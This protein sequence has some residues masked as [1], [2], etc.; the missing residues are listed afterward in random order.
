[1]VL[2]G[3]LGDT[4]FE[5]KLRNDNRIFDGNVRHDL[6]LLR[7]SGVEADTVSNLEVFGTDRAGEHRGVMRNESFE[8]LSNACGFLG[9]GDIYNFSVL[10]IS[11]D[12]AAHSGDYCCDDVYS[13]T[14]FLGEFGDIV[15]STEEVTGE[16]SHLCGDGNFLTALES[17]GL[18]Y[19]EGVVAVPADLEKAFTEVAVDGPGAFDSGGD[20]GYYSGLAAPDC[21]T[22][23]GA[24]GEPTVVDLA[25]LGDNLTL[26]VFAFGENCGEVF[27]DEDTTGTD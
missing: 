1:V 23:T 16:F 24:Y 2:E 11:N 10:W 13:L 6:G 25:E 14:L 27:E 18:G 26:V 22:L 21:R 5:G 12:S 9:E 3:G 17:C 15:G 7:W 4:E 8:T 20:S 19:F